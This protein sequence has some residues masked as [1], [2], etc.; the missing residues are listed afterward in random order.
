[1]D[2]SSK[3]LGGLTDTYTF[4]GFR[5]QQVIRAMPG[6]PGACLITLTRRSKKR[7]VAAAIEF[8]ADGTTG[9]PVGSGI[10]RAAIGA[11][12]WSSRFDACSARTALRWSASDFLADNPFYTK[13]FAF[14]VGKRCRSAT[15]REVAEELHLD[16]DMV[17]SLEKQ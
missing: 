6:D 16:W 10:C 8:K 4:E 7:H 1:M 15:I 17:K 13:R 2:T 14:Y 11:C 12:S 3:R 5:P 9:A